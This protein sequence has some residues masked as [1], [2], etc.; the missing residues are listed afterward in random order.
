MKYKALYQIEH[1]L[2]I[3]YAL[4]NNM[5]ESSNNANVT[6]NGVTKNYAFNVRR[7]YALVLSTWIQ[8]QFLYS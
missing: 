5:H 1:I 7:S 2:C 8:A 6:G 3:W 4:H